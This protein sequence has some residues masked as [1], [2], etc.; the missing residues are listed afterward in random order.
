M[1][2]VEPQSPATP[3]TK[4]PF[5]SKLAAHRRESAHILLNA[6]IQEHKLSIAAYEVEQ[7]ELD[8]ERMKTDAQQELEHSE[9]GS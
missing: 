1:D 7:T 9:V 3:S 5:W 4:N 6:E 8:W 2:L